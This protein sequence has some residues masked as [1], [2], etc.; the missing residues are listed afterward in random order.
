MVRTRDG[1]RSKSR[2]WKAGM[3]ASSVVFLYD[4]DNETLAF[5]HHSQMNDHANIHAQVHMGL[6]QKRT[7]SIRSWAQNIGPTYHR[8]AR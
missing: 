1:S 6:R 3:S 8:S 2:G 4:Y 5:R 7:S